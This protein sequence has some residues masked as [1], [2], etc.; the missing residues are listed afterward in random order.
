MKLQVKRWIS[1]FSFLVAANLGA[2][3]L[4]TGFCYPFFYCHSCPASTSACPLRA[5]EIGMFKGNIRWSFIFYPIFIIGFVGV[6]TGRAVC[7]WACPIGLLQRV[8]G[9]VPRK[10]KKKYP[11]L[12][13]L[14]QHKIDRYL[15]YI[16]YVLFLS[17]VVIL[18]F[19][20]GFMFTNICPIGFLTGTIPISVL[21][22]GEYLPSGFF[23][24]ALVIFIL[25]I[26]L[27]FTVERGWC[28]YFCPIGA[29]LAPFNKVSM[30]Q[31]SVDRDKCAHCNVC[32]NKCPMGIDIPNMDRDPE[33]I[34]CG[35]CI[36]ACPKGAVF[37]ER[38]FLNEKSSIVRKIA[39]KN[40]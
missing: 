1:Q 33:C 19:W 22:S 24:I 12:N 5:I 6:L 40:S 17:L 9:R 8:T 20:I 34:L 29:M 11:S 18:P 15:R 26:V 31:V 27:I 7:G 38:G 37:Y 35:K 16:K 30:L 36:D 10:L 14:G 21:Y 13:K 3:G 28:R 25:F 4:K 23:Y 2:L 32:S 39:E